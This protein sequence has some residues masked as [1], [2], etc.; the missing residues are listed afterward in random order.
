M[1]DLRSEGSRPLRKRNRK[2]KVKTEP[3]EQSTKRS[4][5]H[6]NVLA[7]STLNNLPWPGDLINPYDPVPVIKMA[8]SDVYVD[9]CP[10]EPETQ[11]SLFTSKARRKG[12]VIMDI[13]PANL[14]TA[15]VIEA[16]LPV[17]YR[18][19]RSDKTRNKSRQ[20]HFYEFLC[21][22]E[23]ANDYLD[24]PENKNLYWVDLVACQSPSIFMQS[25]SKARNSKVNCNFCVKPKL[26]KDGSAQMQLVACR[27][28]HQFDELLGDYVDTTASEDSEETSQYNSSSSSD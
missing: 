19:R 14:T 12:A 28:L 9:C 2:K 23:C 6:N 1:D 25:C 17:A 8:E 4:K 3:A 16:C 21:A 22:G 27:K 26:N 10:I 18:K 24:A 11:R 20:R 7:L 15:Q 13:G 5:Y